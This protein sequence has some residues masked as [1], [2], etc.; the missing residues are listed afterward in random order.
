MS[1]DVVRG[2]LISLIDRLRDGRVL[3]IGDV[4]LDRY[5][6]GDVDRI[7]PEAPVPVCRVTDEAMMLGGAGNVA[8]N[9]AALGAGVDFVSVVGDDAAGADIRRLL[10]ELGDL[11][12]VGIELIVD[13]TRPTTIKERFVAGPQQLLRVDRESDLPVE[14]AIAGQV[15]DA[16]RRALGNVQAIVISDYGKG[17]LA[18]DALAALIA[19]AS[20]AGCAIIVD[21]KGTDFARYHGADVV[22]PNQREL[23]A[24][25]QM[26][27]D[28][29]DGVVAAARMLVAGCGIGHVLATRSRD[30]MTLVSAEGADHFAAEAR[31]VFDVSGAGDTVVAA[32]AAGLAAGINLSDAARLANVAAGI[33]VGKIGTAVVY[34]ADIAE[35]LLRSDA[36]L[37]GMRK[38]LE[39]EDALERIKA[40]RGRGETVGFTNGCFDLLHPGHVALLSSARAACDRLVVALNSD[41]SVRRLKGD[42]RPVQDEASRAAVMGSLASV[43]L[44][45]LFEDDTPLRLIEAILP[46]VLVKGADYA[47]DEVVG[48]DIVTANGGR[49]MLVDLEKG[50]ST[51]N[52]I[53]RMA[54]RDG[55]A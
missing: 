33:V 44:V 10:G 4:M 43:D 3:C 19:A 34:P 22:T 51:T 14:P 47:V 32:L 45:M 2:D 7:S 23:S 20:D 38:W 1:G 29:D 17:V 31:E 55:S 27:T 13:S 21:P 11:G 54:G 24:A 49:V 37:D 36:R 9:L 53:G 41:A 28:D 26:P 18:D 52:T 35:Q 8:R 48:G 15:F 16:A 5:V 46:D 39:F 25:S 30:G 40:W 12:S 42:D 6:Y 50:H